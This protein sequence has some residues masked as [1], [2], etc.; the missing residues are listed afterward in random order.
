MV[1]VVNHS[2]IGTSCRTLS[3]P[4][5]P[6]PN[7][8]NIQRKGETDGFGYHDL[9]KLTVGN[10]ENHK[11]WPNKFVWI[12]RWQVCAGLPQEDGEEEDRLPED[13][14]VR[15][16]REQKSVTAAGVRQSDGQEIEQT[17]EKHDA[18]GGAREDV[19]GGE[20]VTVHGRVEGPWKQTVQTRMDSFINA[21]SL[22]DKSTMWLARTTQNMYRDA[23]QL[24]GQ[25][26]G[27]AHE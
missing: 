22:K 18:A 5:D 8:I 11:L 26:I 1:V 13:H 27:D 6:S 3:I 4:N 23:L 14:H 24:S 12:H 17:L 16:E 7:F 10:P 25:T 21:Q 20:V 2:F 9:H 19:I 15:G